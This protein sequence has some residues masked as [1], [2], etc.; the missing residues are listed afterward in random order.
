VSI[1]KDGALTTPRPVPGRLLPAA[2][3][4][5]VLGLALVV[6]LVAGWDLAGWALGAVLWAGLEAVGLLIAHARKQTSST[7]SSGVLALGLLFRTTAALVVL[8]AA[9][10]S[11]PDVALAAVLVF[12]LAYTFELVLSLA[13]YFGPER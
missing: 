2:G 6:F 10:A 5:L 3:A 9:A 11:N 13:T 1:V 7:A 12:A 8:V 4:L